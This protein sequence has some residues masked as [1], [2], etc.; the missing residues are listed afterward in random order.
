MLSNTLDVVGCVV[1][2]CGLLWGWQKFGNAHKIDAAYKWHPV[3]FLWGG[4]E[5]C[6]CVCVFVC[7]LHHKLV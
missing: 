1:C 4:G 7:C 6:V 2:V 3:C 5:G